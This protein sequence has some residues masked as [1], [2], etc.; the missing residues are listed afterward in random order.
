MTA[1]ESE[2]RKSKRREEKLQAMM[3]RLS[4]DVK[5]SGG[6]ENAL[7]TLRSVR[8]LEFDLD[9]AQNQISR[10][11][12][13]LAEQQEHQQQQQR[14][15]GAAKGSPTLGRSQPKVLERRDQNVA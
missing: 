9:R 12:S 6:C 11:R 14:Q 13:Q 1:L 4:L 15:A 7:K 5:E 2:L 10:L 8:E 3:Y